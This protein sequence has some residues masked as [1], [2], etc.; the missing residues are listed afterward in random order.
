MIAAAF[1]CGTRRIAT[2]QWQ[3]ASEGYDPV[4]NVGSPS[5]HS[6]SHYGG[7]NP[8]ERW[9][10]IDRWYAERFAY[11]ISSLKKVGVLD[12]TIIAWVSEISQEHTL[13]NHVIP[14]AGGQA[15][16]M[17]TGQYVLYPFTGR[18]FDHEN[19]ARDP[20]HKSYSDLWVT[21]QQAMGIKRDTFGDA[22]WNDG[23]LTELR[24]A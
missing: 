19:A 14:L 21:V 4:S 23:P 15:L 22:Q 3:G 24:D 5:H 10:A 17:K 8:Q 11:A 1:A 9:A 20:K 18:E 6:I 2:I 16:G 12:R 13:N 7:P